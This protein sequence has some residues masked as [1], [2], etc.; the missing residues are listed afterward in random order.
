MAGGGQPGWLAEIVYGL[1][2]AVAANT[3]GLFPIPAFCALAVLI[4]ADQRLEEEARLHTGP[5]RVLLSVSLPIALPGIVT[6]MIL[7]FLLAVVDFG[8]A[9]QL[10][11]PVYPTEIFT[12]FSA[13]YNAKRAVASSVPLVAVCLAVIAAWRIRAI[14]WDS[15][16][17][18][19]PLALEA[20]LRLCGRRRL[21]AR[22]VMLLPILAALSPTTGLLSCT[23]LEAFT[24]AFSTAS[25]EIRQSLMLAPLSSVLCAAVGLAGVMLGGVCLKVGW[26]STALLFI[27]PGPVVGVS[28]V[29]FWNRPGILGT[30]Y[31]TDAMLVLGMVTRFLFVALIVLSISNQSI[32]RWIREQAMVDGAGR[33]RTFLSIVFPL[34]VPGVLVAL[35][36]CA[37]LILGELGVS[38]LVVPPGGTTLAVRIMTLMHYGPEPVLSATALILVIIVLFPAS[39]VSGVVY[40][41]IRAAQASKP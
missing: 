8:V 22:C 15:P 25:D 6:G 21:L 10:L 27:L 37:T 3:L 29:T 19:S 26:I 34:M 30:L 9:D 18:A 32:G 5:L 1:P 14:R 17:E 13:F 40:R 31:G 7:V 33:I 4:G 2:G 24:E 11:Y 16:E 35:L 39:V 20:P 12:Q 41:I 28:L 38:V 23:S 36:L